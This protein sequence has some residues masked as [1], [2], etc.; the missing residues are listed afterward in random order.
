MMSSDDSEI[1]KC[2]K[3]GWYTDDRS[4]SDGRGDIA[5]KK[6]DERRVEEM[7][8]K[9]AAEKWMHDLE[10]KVIEMEETN[11]KLRAEL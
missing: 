10:D 3:G 7:W 4:Y 9:S 5:N 2:S 8:I 6:W 1:D 11:R